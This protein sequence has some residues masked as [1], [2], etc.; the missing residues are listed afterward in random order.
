LCVVMPDACGLGGDLMALVRAGGEATVAVTGAGRAPG[1]EPVQGWGGS[2]G[3]LVTTPGLVHA[4]TAMHQ[5]WGRLPLRVVLAPAIRLARDG[6]TPDPALLDALERQRGRL[7]AN[8]AAEWHL[9][10]RSS[11]EPWTQHLLAGVLENIAAAGA[12]GFYGGAL[13]A[14]VARA[15]QRSGGSLSAPDLAAHSTVFGE[16]IVVPWAGGE[17]AVQP[18]PSQGVLLAMALRCLDALDRAPDPDDLDHLLVELAL[19]AFEHR[20]RCHRGAELLAEP[21]GIDAVRASNRSGPRSYLHTA[22]VAVVDASGG[23]VSSLVSLFD[24]FGSAVYVPEGGF[25]LNNRA[26]GF[27]DGENAARPCGRP[28]HTLA[29]SLIAFP[30]GDLYGIATPGADGQVQTLLQLFARLRWGGMTMPEALAAPRWRSEQG[31]LLMEQSHPSA[32]RLGRMGHRVEL[33]RIGDPA[34]GAVVVAGLQSE[35]AVAAADWRRAVQA[36]GA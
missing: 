3:S 21:L 28:V 35:H 1:T 9:L 13:G 5:R 34:F 30:S 23:V 32:G 33:R 8:G 12:P 16:P 19:A 10:T 4:W 20:S 15:A 11:G 27:T 14:A 6:I 18:P 24:D 2:V 17:I 25:T 22:G 31:L 36:G 7:M 26:D 29:P